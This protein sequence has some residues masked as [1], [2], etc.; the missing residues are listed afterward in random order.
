MQFRAYPDM[1]LMR[2]TKPLNVAPANQCTPE[3]EERLVDIGPPLV[4]HLQA[5]VAVQPRQRPLHHPPVPAQPL[6]RV[7]APSG[8]ARLYAPLAQRLAAA[9]KVVTL[10]G[11]QLL[12]ALARPPGLAPWPADRPDTAST[13][14]S[15]AFES[16]TLAALRTTA[17]GTPPRSTTRWRFEP[18]LPRSVGFGPAFWP[19]RGRAPPPS[20][21][22]LATSRCGLPAPGGVQEGSV[23][24]LPD[25]GL[26]PLPQAAPAGHT[27]AA[28]HL[29]R[30]HLPRDAR[31]EHEQDA[32]KRGPVVDA[33]STAP[34]L[35]RFLGQER[36]Y[37]R[38]QFVVHEWFR[39]DRIVPDR[40]VSLGVLRRRS[41]IAPDSWR[42]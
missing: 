40:R 20:R 35:G 24:A 4:A 7:H 19:P 29:L 21:A 9:P 28:A 1:D 31:L 11:V 17:S 15:S 5:S 8:D 42:R 16:W 26:V 36:F 6:A 22:R 23:Q 33:R 39:H 27:R 18:C 34:G 32:G 10:V 12:G 30:E 14:S 25:A 3:V 37:D 2:L 13:A 38:P 41:R